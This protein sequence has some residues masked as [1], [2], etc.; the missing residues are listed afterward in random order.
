MSPMVAPI[1][2]GISAC[3]LGER[4]RYDGDHKWTPGIVHSLRVDVRWIPVCPE[5]EAGMGVPREPVH[6]EGDPAA[7][8][9]IG[10]TSGTD[11]TEVMRA[12]LTRTVESLAVAGIRGY[13]LKARSPSCGL[14]DIP[15]TQPNGESPGRG[16]FA[17]ALLERLPGLPV[18][19][20]DD[21]AAAEA[22]REFLERIRAYS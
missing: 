6:L 22:R 20:E 19:D 3:L 13:V 16:L 7:P 1:P 21:L 17:A 15:V 5:V 14:R 4:V 9:M 12:T 8:S 11:W 18:A 10:G 2:V